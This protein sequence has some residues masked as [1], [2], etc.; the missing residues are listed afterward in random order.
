MYWF[1][2][3]GSY[4]LVNVSKFSDDQLR[5]FIEYGVGDTVTFQIL[6]YRVIGFE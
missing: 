4:Y 6:D 2:I 3:D 5:L 1:E